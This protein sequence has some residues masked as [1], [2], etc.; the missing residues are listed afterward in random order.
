MSGAEIVPFR[1]Q[2]QSYDLEEKLLGAVLALPDRM[3]LFDSMGLMREDFEGARLGLAFM[4]AQRLAV[5]RLEVNAIT[6]AS[7]GKT[8]GL[9][10]DGDVAWLAGLQHSNL[11][12]RESTLQLAEEIRQRARARLV[13]AAMQRVL[14]TIDRGHF[15]PARMAA[16]LESIVHGLATDF[17]VDETAEGE[18]IALNEGWKK[19]ADAGL[20][21]LDP[22]GIRVLDSIIGGTPENL[23]LIQGQR[24]TGKNVLA[25]TMIRAQLERDREAPKPEK[26]GIFW[27][28]DGT[29]ALL[30][31][32]QAEDLGIPLRE[33]GWKQLTPEQQ[34]RKH[35]ID[36]HHFNLLKRIVHYRHDSI[37]RAELRRRAMRMIF[38][39]GVRRIYVD[40]MK[41]IDHRDPRAKL[42][43]WAA[44]AETTRVMRNLARDTG[45]PVI[46]LVHDTEEAAKEGQEKPPD[47]GKMM[48]GQSGGDR[49]R[50]VLGVWRKGQSL[51][52]T[53][54]KGNEISDAG[55]KGPTVELQRNFE[56]GTANPEGGRVIDLKVEEAKDRREKREEKR[57]ESAE[58]S[59]L[60]S[61]L[62]KEMKTKALPAGEAQPAEVKKPEAQPVLLEVPP[63]TKPEP[64][65]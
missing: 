10:S 54:T 32:W 21:T 65:P 28:E 43:Y 45:V 58:E 42:E 26:T 47:P 57:V 13:R 37:S 3:S 9:L 34:E 35:Y 1:A 5:R 24:G 51:R 46:M 17:S 27:L 59:V 31:R 29:Q 25:T 18:I 20:S 36:A 19:N 15:S 48:G 61:A 39:D 30:R 55:L 44:V 50:L 12:S 40:N 56:A 63:S 33:V 52:V 8:H 49:A 11:L 53:V 22:T 62:V 7:T 2:Q 64:K 60:R 41:E 14:D 38:K 6:V 4:V 16:E 23:T